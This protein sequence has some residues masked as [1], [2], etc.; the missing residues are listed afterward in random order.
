MAAP[1]LVVAAPVLAPTETV[2]WVF[3]VMSGALAVVLLAGHGAQERRAALWS[4]ALVGLFVWAGSIAEWFRPV[5]EL[6]TTVIGTSLVAGA[7]YWNVRLRRRACRF[8]PLG[9]AA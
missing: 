2:E 9:E 1:V 3:F 6:V 8:S 7:L 4:L 5:P